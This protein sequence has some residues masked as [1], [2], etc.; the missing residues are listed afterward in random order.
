VAAQTAQQWASIYCTELQNWFAAI[1]TNV[2]GIQF[3]VLQ[4]RSARELR[5]ELAER[6]PYLAMNTDFFIE[7]MEKAGTPP[8]VPHEDAVF[9]D[10]LGAFA[11]YRDSALGIDELLASPADARTL[12]RTA[13]RVFNGLQNAL[14]R[15]VA[16]LPTALA[17][18]QPPALARPLQELPECDAVEETARAPLPPP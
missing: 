18:S 5:R 10:L 2:R 9:E 1:R 6:I 14:A 4:A 13:R 7:K 17:T 11:A 15:V 16:R 8:G 3:A 12:K